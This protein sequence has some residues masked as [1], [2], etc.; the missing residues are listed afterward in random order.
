MS[1]GSNR[2]SHDFTFFTNMRWNHVCSSTTCHLEWTKC[3][4]HFLSQVEIP[5]VLLNTVAYMI[6]CGMTVT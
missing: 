3:Q 4:G 2:Q 5:D 6:R 1:F